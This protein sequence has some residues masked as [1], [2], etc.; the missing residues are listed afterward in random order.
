VHA[1]YRVA[2]YDPGTAQ[3]LWV[4]GTRYIDGRTALTLR[5]L[6]TR[7][8]N[9]RWTGGWMLRLDREPSDT[10]RWHLG[11]V[12]SYESLASTVFDFS[13][14]LRSR[15]VF[16]GIYREFSPSLG[17]KLDAVHEWTAG[18]PDRNSLHAGFV[19]RF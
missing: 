1:D 5:G 8:L 18:T 10:L 7:N 4:G 11:F 2:S 6:A 3:S 15:A 17:L 14:R 19:T 13:R 9:H 16:G 12:D